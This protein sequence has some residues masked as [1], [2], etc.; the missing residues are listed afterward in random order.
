M[1]GEVLRKARKGKHFTMSEVAEMVGV[2]AGYISNLEKN[3]LEPSLTLLRDLAE[4][5]GVPPS[6]LI[7]EEIVEYVT[8]IPAAERP[9]LR[10]SNLPCPCEVLAPISWHCADSD[11]I[12][13]IQITVPP[14]IAIPMDSVSSDADICI[15]VLSGSITYHY[16]ADSILIEHD[17][18]I[19]IPRNTVN[20]IESSGSGETGMLWMSKTLFKVHQA[21]N[22]MVRVKNV[23]T[24]E[25]AKSQQL[26]LLG[27]RMR[28]LRKSFGIGIKAFAEIVGVTPAYI[29]QIERNL[30][31]P[32]LRVL[33]KIARELN[34]ELTLLFASDMPSDVLVTESCKRDVMRIAD[35]NARLQLLV[36]YHTMDGRTPDMS[37]VL[38]DL[39]AGQADCEESIVHDYDELCIVLE[40]SVEYQ[41]SEGTFPLAVG[42]SLYI[43]KGIHHK[44]YN[45]Y[46]CNAR[47]LVVLGSVIQRK[48]R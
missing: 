22:V 24:A 29:S 15:Y 34:V 3:R 33:R 31:E 43:R 38:V 5:L 20:R 19:F 18:S 17:G 16:G 40:G 8:M 32:S 45:A 9:R 44:I 26:Q 30:T 37:V 13:A 11:E 4:K 6:A 7:S 46:G 42:D 39:G 1:I 2:T 25:P 12:E 21:E 27:E 10:Y 41:T 28:D 14:G 48:L 36:P 35:S 47:I 23:R